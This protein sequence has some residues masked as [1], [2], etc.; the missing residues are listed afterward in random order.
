MEDTSEILH[1]TGNY[2]I[3]NAKKKTRL[4]SPQNMKLVPR[5]R[6]ADERGH[7][8]QK[9]AGKWTATRRPLGVNIARMRSQLETLSQDERKLLDVC[10]EIAE[11]ALFL[12]GR[13][14]HTTQNTKQNF[15][16]CAREAP[17]SRMRTLR[18][19]ICHRLRQTR[20][21][22]CQNPPCFHHDVRTPGT[23]NQRFN[24]TSLYVNRPKLWKFPE[25]QVLL[26]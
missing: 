9:T 11:S 2:N 18:W 13:K 15:R 20:T 23:N 22:T 12:R 19:T 17:T 6:G 21:A 24:L 8:L 3:C 10:R 25:V 14:K 4:F 7:L 16:F 5:R 26:M 1:R